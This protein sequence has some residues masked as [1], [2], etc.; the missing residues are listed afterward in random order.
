MGTGSQ[1]LLPTDGI[2]TDTVDADVDKKESGDAEAEGPD[3][4]IRGGAIKADEDFVPTGFSCRVA[5]VINGGSA[6]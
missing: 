1:S 3:T 6:P 4:D 5:D 2:D